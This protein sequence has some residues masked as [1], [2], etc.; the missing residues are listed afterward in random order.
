ML[1][2]KFNICA[3][4]LRRY[5]I[6][7]R[8]KS[9]FNFRVAQTFHFVTCLPFTLFHDLSSLCLQRSSELSH[10][11][12]SPTRISGCL[13][14][15]FNVIWMCGFHGVA[16]NI[17]KKMNEPD[18]KRLRLHRELGRNWG[19]QPN[20]LLPSKS[21]CLARCSLRWLETGCSQERWR[22]PHRHTTT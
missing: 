10:Y 4:W 7:W 9:N 3:T 11:Y 6:I 18:H 14:F 12:R 20:G 15:S 17:R 1:N 8:K 16:L 19:R 21:P 13:I 2:F 5:M 22:F